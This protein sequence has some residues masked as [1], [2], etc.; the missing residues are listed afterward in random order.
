MKLETVPTPRF[1]ESIETDEMKIRLNKQMEVI[2]AD[3]LKP[4][5][6]VAL[7]IKE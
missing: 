3:A 6:Y 7:K 1:F 5:L 4:H 2:K